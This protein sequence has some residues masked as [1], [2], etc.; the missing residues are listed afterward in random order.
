[1]RRLGRRRCKEGRLEGSVPDALNEGSVPEI[2]I[3][4]DVDNPCCAHVG[5]SRDYS[6]LRQFF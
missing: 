5:Y 4:A 1:M 6:R 2:I 3:L